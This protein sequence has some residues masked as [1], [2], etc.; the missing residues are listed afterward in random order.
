MNR[1]K[2][3]MSLLLSL[4]MLSTCSII[5]CHAEDQSQIQNEA[6]ATYRYLS[7][8][9]ELIPSSLS[10]AKIIMFQTNH[11]DSNSFNSVKELTDDGIDVF[12]DCNLQDNIMKQ[13]MPKFTLPASFCDEQFLGIYIYDCGM[14]RKVVPVLSLCMYEEGT[15]IPDQIKLEDYKKIKKQKDLTPYALYE[16]FG[17]HDQ[18][19]LLSKNSAQKD[20]AKLQTMNFNISNLFF[21][22]EVFMYA[23]AKSTSNTEWNEG[24]L[25]G[26]YKKLGYA[27]LRLVMNSIGNAIGR[28]YDNALICTTVGAYGNY[29]V[30]KY[31]TGIGV[32][33]QVTFSPKKPND[34]TNATVTNSFATSIKSDGTVQNTSTV[35]TTYNPTGQ[36]FSGSYDTSNEYYVTATPA[37]KKKGY[38]WESVTTA[39]ISTKI[40][41]TGILLV[42]LTNLKIYSILTYTWGDTN[43]C[44]NLSIF[45]NHATTTQL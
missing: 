42:G 38:S 37:S 15:I 11:L 34:T 18:T 29:A 45:R 10:N 17:E 40:N 6:T 14:G 5:S 1:L 28:N 16:T 23:Y 36:S 30:K 20:M 24:Q 8:V 39:T 33:N 32:A 44:A 35:S 3:M 25:G 31:T 13:F 43:C 4:L 26:S 21:D 27:K 9:E 22:E 2:K 41:T 12:I 7:S 19:K